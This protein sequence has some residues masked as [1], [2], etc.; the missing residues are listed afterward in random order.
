[1]SACGRDLIWIRAPGAR[2][3]G[4][5]PRAVE[6]PSEKESLAAVRRPQ[7]AKSSENPS[8]PAACA[9][10]KTLLPERA[11]GSAAFGGQNL[12]EAEC[13]PFVG[14]GQGPFSAG[15]EGRGVSRPGPVFVFGP[16]GMWEVPAL[17]VINL[18]ICQRRACLAALWV[19]GFRRKNGWKNVSL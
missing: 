8:F 15:R 11:W 6:T 4:V 9:L 1:M 16:G 14:K 13:H 3:R 5:P 18:P 12:G 7:M 2:M 19:P 10:G 17:P